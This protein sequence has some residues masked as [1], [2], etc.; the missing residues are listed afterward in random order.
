MSLTATDMSQVAS[1]CISAVNGADWDRLRALIAPD[2]SYTENGT[3]RRT[4]G[5]DAYMELVK[6][7][8]AAFPDFT[9]TIEATA[10]SDDTVAQRIVWEGTHAGVLDT[11]AGPVQP[12]GHRVRVVSSAWSR[13][14][15]DTIREIHFHIDALTMRE[16]IGAMT[17]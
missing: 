13:F 2:L 7:T 8:R 6:G 14:E 3:R 1:D 11:P 9:G 16:Q 12:S 10:A 5:A 17:G 15:G 4:D